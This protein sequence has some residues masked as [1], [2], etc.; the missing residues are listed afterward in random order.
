MKNIHL[1]VL[2]SF[3]TTISSFSQRTG[4][5]YVRSDRAN[6]QV[7]W[8]EIGREASNRIMKISRDREKAAR[9]LGWSSAAEMDAARR[10]N[11][12][13]LRYERRMRKIQYKIN[14]KKGNLN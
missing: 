12:R 5:G 3:F 7:N 4:Y 8:A 10:A 6:N 9:E 13:K 1:V 11:N 14:K 2:I